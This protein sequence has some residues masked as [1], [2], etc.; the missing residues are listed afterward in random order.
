MS[1][2]DRDKAPTEHRTR[3]WELPDCVRFHLLSYR[4]ITNIARHFWIPECIMVYTKNP[5]QCVLRYY[6]PPCR[7]DDLRK[8]QINRR[9]RPFLRAILQ[10]MS[11]LAMHPRPLFLRKDP[12]AIVTDP[13]GGADH[14]QISEPV[15]GVLLTA[16]GVLIAQ[17]VRMLRAF[18]R[19]PETLNKAV[20]AAMIKEYSEQLKDAA[21]FDQRI[22]DMENEN[23]KRYGRLD[24]KLDGIIRRL[25]HRG[26]AAG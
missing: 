16:L 15:R 20:I 10:S 5:V 17:L 24:A 7:S 22:T 21:Y 3:N 2:G 18:R 14:N 19:P 1:V 9:H 25:D 8:K 12:A 4:A 26:A 13:I 6:T 23:D 11:L